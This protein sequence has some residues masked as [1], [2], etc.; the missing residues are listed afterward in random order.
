MLHPS[1]WKSF[2]DS[3]STV[4]EEQK[5]RWT[6]ELHNKHLEHIKNNNIKQPREIK[7]IVS[8]HIWDFIGPKHYIFPQLHFE[9]GV[10]N[11]VLDNFY[12][13]IEDQIEVLSTE[14]KV[15]RNSVTIAES[16]LEVSKKELEEWL[17]D[18][19]FTLNNLRLQKLNI[20]AALKRRTL[21][22]DERSNLLSEREITDGNISLMTDERKRMETGITLKRKPVGE[23]KKA[24]KK[25]QSDQKKLICQ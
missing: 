2:G 7:G 4:P 21:T 18:T 13:F 8:E 9:I 19:F 24:L 20:A 11:M 14:E 16:S 5:Q 12:N 1:E 6:V 15:A 23:K 3:P 22:Q 17:S 10:V 25:I